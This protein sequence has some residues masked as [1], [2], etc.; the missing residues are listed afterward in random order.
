MTLIDL[1][2]FSVIIFEILVGLYV[3][4]MSFHEN[5]AWHIISLVWGGAVIW[6]GGNILLNLLRELVLII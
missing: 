1:G 5:G 3:F 2:E 4:Y 6:L